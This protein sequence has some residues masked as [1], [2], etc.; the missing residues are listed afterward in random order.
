MMD[1]IRKH[2]PTPTEEEESW[3]ATDAASAVVRVFLLAVVSLS[4]GVSATLLM[5]HA[6]PTPAIAAAAQ[7]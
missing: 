7:Q 1:D 3:M 4:L 2:D 5:G 6:L